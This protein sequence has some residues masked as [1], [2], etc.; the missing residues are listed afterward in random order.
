[1]KKDWTEIVLMTLPYILPIVSYL[2]GRALNV[3]KVPPAVANLLKDGEV[4]DLIRQGI[5]AGND[6]TGKT[7]AEKQAYV[8]E[9]ALGEMRKLTGE[10]LSDSTINFLIEHAIIRS[11]A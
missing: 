10:W 8:R 2:I 6:Q 3:I 9:W 5:A 4:M 1:M 7:N 11:K